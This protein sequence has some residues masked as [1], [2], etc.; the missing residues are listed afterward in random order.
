MDS[1][2]WLAPNQS[3]D[4]GRSEEKTEEIEKI[5]N[6]WI[7]I[8]FWDSEKVFNPI[9]IQLIHWKNQERVLIKPEDKKVRTYLL[10]A[11]MIIVTE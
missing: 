1:W 4:D 9:K 6:D 2:W 8:N 5:T 7:Q 10:I 3:I 11:L